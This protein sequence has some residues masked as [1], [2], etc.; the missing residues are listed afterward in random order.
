V[1]AVTGYG[2]T[3]VRELAN[4]VAPI[5][6][7]RIEADLARLDARFILPPGA[8]RFVLAAGVIYSKSIRAQSADEIVAGV[9]VNMV[10]V[11]RLCE[12]ILDTV[13][14]ARICVIASES[15]FKGSFDESYAMSKAGVVTYVATRAVKCSQ[16]LVAIAPPIIAD[17]GMTQRRHD[18]PDVLSHR[19]HVFARDVAANVY[20][21]LY[22]SET[23]RNM[24]D[25]M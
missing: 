12:T 17:S 7:R 25:R 13:P 15:A 20:R 14:A 8:T 4:L 1:I 16:L 24:V 3:I 5:E 18:Y 10:N 11:A 6:V 9:A 2:T 23:G 21:H 19:R 22:E